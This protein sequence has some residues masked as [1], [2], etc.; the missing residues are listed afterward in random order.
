[1]DELEFA[2][3]QIIATRRYTQKLLDITPA[4]RWFSFPEPVHTH[5]AWQVG[6]LAMAQF[7]LC[8]YYVRPVLAED[9]AV[10]SDAFMS[11]FRAGTRPVADPAAYPPLDEILRTFNAIHEHILGNWWR[12]A[13]MDMHEHANCHP[14]RVVTTRLDAL[15]WAARHEMLHTGQIGLLRRLL[16]CESMW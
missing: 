14:H 10:I 6:H 3:Q 13:E 16:G 15:T 1:M 9:Q 7:R 4:D 2:R 12:Y 8:I 5:I 11:H